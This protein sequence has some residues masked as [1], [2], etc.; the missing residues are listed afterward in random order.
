MWD[1]ES[2][3]YRNRV[4]HHCHKPMLSHHR[5]FYYDKITINLTKHHKLW[6]QVSSICWPSFFKFLLVAVTGE[7]AVK[8]I[9]TLFNQDRKRKKAKSRW[10][11]EVLWTALWKDRKKTVV[12]KGTFKIQ[13]LKNRTMGVCCWNR[14]EVIGLENS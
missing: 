3:W 7:T 1:K 2:E 5:L 8:E 9:K 4:K 10:K 14:E 13:D 12:R 6:K 11:T